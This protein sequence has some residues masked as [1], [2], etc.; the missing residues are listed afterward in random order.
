MTRKKM[1][2]LALSAVLALGLSVSASAQATAPSVDESV[3][4]EAAQPVLDAYKAHYVVEDVHATCIT[5]VP[6]ENGGYYVEYILNFDAALKYSSA[7]ETP[8]VRGI[9]KALHIDP[10]QSVDAFLAEMRSVGTAR[11]VDTG[12]RSG[13]K[14]KIGAAWNPASAAD[15]LSV[16]LVSALAETSAIRQLDNFIKEIEEEYIGESSE[17]N[18]GLRA[19]IDAQGN[20]TEL[21]YGTFDGYSKDISSVIPES[22]KELVREGFAE[23]LA[24][25]N[26]TATAAM[27]NF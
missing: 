15:T 1:I 21:E 6:K 5:E 3:L 25:V 19:S 26:E 14:Q 11:G 27:A 22:E 9:A 20:L 2:S 4:L 18:V 24:Q 23:G 17:F 8:R 10:D 7:L 13:L 16:S 12:A